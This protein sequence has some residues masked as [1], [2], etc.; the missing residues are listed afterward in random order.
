M[1]ERFH[2]SLSDEINRLQELNE[3]DILH[4]LPEESFDRITRIVR[5]VF[6]VPICVISFVT[7][8]KQWFK[9]CI[10]LPV[11]L[12]ASRTTDRDI[13][14]CQYVVAFKNSFVVPDAL[15]DERFA[16]NPLVQQY[17]F[18]FYAGAPLLSEKGNV[19]GSLCL[20]DY[21]TREW[22]TDDTTLLSEFSR[23]VMAELELRHKNQQLKQTN[24]KLHTLSI[25]DGLTGVFNRRLF[26]EKLKCEWERA[27]SSLSSVALILIDIDCFKQF[28]DTYGHLNGD[29]CLKLV[30]KAIHSAS[31]FPHLLA[32][33]YGGE[34]FAVLLP[35]LNITEA[36]EIA[37]QIRRKVYSLQIPHQNSSTSRYVTL[38]LGVA[39]DT[40]SSKDGATLLLEKADQALYRAKASGRNQT[41]EYK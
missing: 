37:E 17:G 28:N 13:S 14:F 7:E 22:K 33:R 35:G 32:A 11:E 36:V 2:T 25:F 31:S 8:D 18:R 20:Y 21:K 6:Q 10:G 29:E 16:N 19:L 38:S 27:L 4:T 24:Q 34:E 40:P 15:E 30:A 1:S 12:D 26:D 9:S 39:A 23:W 3:L 5:Q 41:T